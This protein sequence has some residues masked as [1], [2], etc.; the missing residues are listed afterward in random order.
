VYGDL[1]AITEVL[2]GGRQG[3]GLVYTVAELGRSIAT[4]SKTVE[5][6]MSEVTGS[7]GVQAQLNALRTLI[8]D[9]RKLRNRLI[10]VFCGPVAAG[11]AWLVGRSIFLAVGGHL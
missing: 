7:E 11:L 1:S 8:E 4:Q 5:R 10:P 2:W 9:E 3:P 6:L